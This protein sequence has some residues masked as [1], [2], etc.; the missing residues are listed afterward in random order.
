MNVNIDINKTPEGKH[1]I[2]LTD[3]DG[4]IIKKEE[5][6]EAEAKFLDAAIKVEDEFGHLLDLMEVSPLGRLQHLVLLTVMHNLNTNYTTFSLQH[7]GEGLAKPRRKS[8]ST[9]RQ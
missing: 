2:E 5:I 8:S 3:T 4:E 7:F 9:W 6:S 1:I